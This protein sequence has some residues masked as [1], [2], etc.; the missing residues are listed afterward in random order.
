MWPFAFFVLRENIR[1]VLEC[2][3]SLIAKVAG[4]ARIRQD[5]A[6]LM[7]TI[8]PGVRQESSSRPWG[9][10][11]RRIAPHACRAHIKQESVLLPKQTVR[12]AALVFMGP[13][14]ALH[15]YQTACSALQ[16]HFSPGWG[17]SLLST[18]LLAVQVRI[19]PV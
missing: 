16:A 15:P 11:R 18:V 8:A 7:Q 14:W 3:G 4:L 6:W 5:G 19:R 2:Q 9:Q 13:D 12:S 1:L 17:W 10:W